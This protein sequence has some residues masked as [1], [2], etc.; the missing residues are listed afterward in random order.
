MNRASRQAFLR[1]I[2]ITLPDSWAFSGDGFRVNEQLTSYAVE[3]NQ[4]FQGMRFWESDRS[5]TVPI[6]SHD[7]VHPNGL[8][9]CLTWGSRNAFANLHPQSHPPLA[10]WARSR[11]VLGCE[12]W[13]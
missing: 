4:T 2:P 10:A 6:L 3:S 12:P 11:N 8:L 9:T 7:G 5:D 13:P 1:S